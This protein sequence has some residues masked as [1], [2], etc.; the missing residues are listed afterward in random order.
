ML[1]GTCNANSSLSLHSVDDADFLEKVGKANYILSGYPN[2]SGNTGRTIFQYRKADDSGWAEGYSDKG[3]GVTL[4]YDGTKTKYTI[5]LLIKT[6]DS[7]NNVTYKPMLRLA[8]IED[9]SYT[10]YSMT[11]REITDAISDNASAHA[12]FETSIASKASNE[13]LS[14]LSI[15]TRN[16]LSD[17]NNILGS[18]NI[19]PNNGITRTLNSINFTVNSD[20]S[21]NINGTNN[22]STNAVWY[23][24][25]SSTNANT[26]DILLPKGNYIL[27]NHISLIAGMQV[28]VMTGSTY[29]ASLVNGLS[30][31]SFSLTADTYVHYG[32]RISEGLA[33]T[34]YL[35]KP[36]V[37]PSSISDN[38]YVPYVQTN[39]ELT[40]NKSNVGHTHDDRYYTKTEIDNKLSDTGWVN[41]TSRT[42]VASVNTAKYRIK[43]GICTISI[44]GATPSSTSTVMKFNNIPKCAVAI[45]SPQ[46]YGNANRGTAYIPVNSTTLEMTADYGIACCSFTYPTP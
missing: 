14:Q 24:F 19:M 4:P 35:V 25:S 21:I 17:I 1:N 6:G 26:D 38:T 3:Q 31:K 37:R 12:S 11:N 46:G 29:L 22:S 40:I 9:D 32:I 41:I 42:N 13:A 44:D 39:K 43:N 20:K 45:T 28:A 33:V 5:Y 7:F 27:S 16:E 8:S 15:S 30:E 10:Q 18:K 34:N 36:M 2:I 23:W